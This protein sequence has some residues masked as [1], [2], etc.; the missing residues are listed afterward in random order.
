LDGSIAFR[1]VKRQKHHGRRAWQKT[2]HFMA[3]RK[4]R[5]RER[6]ELRTR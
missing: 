5:K 2:V 4:Q 6:K 3:D 1:P